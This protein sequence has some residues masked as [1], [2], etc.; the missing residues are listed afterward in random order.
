[1]GEQSG[2]RDHVAGCGLGSLSVTTRPLVTPQ[3]VRMTVDRALQDGGASAVAHVGFV[4]TPPDRIRQEALAKQASV[5][6]LTGAL[7]VIAL[8]IATGIGVVN[9]ATLRHYQ[10]LALIGALAAFAGAGLALWGAL[11]GDCPADRCTPR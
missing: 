5:R 7:S 10:W 9:V 3:E 1:M 6:W 2:A 4:A 8:A 11:A